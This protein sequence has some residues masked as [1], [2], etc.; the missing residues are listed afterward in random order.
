MGTVDYLWIGCCQRIPSTGPLRKTEVKE[1]EKV[2]DEPMPEV[3]QALRHVEI[4][5]IDFDIFPADK[6][7]IVSARTPY[8]LAAPQRLHFLGSGGQGGAGRARRAVSAG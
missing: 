3:K 2:K 7:W 6:N 8:I 5:E 4:L 1:E